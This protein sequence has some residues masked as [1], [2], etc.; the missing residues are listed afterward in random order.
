MVTRQIHDKTMK[1][2]AV[3]LVQTRGKSQRQIA[4]DLPAASVEDRFRFIE[5]TTWRSLFER[6][7]DYFK[8]ACR[9]LRASPAQVSGGASR[10]VE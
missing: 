10:G 8:A 9:T 5:L 1:Q 2:K 3:H 7:Y 6:D 4:D